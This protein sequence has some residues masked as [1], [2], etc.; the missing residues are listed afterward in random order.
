VPLPLLHI[1]SITGNFSQHI[2]TGIDLESVSDRRAFNRPVRIAYCLKSSPPVHSGKHT[3]PIFATLVRSS[4][5]LNAHFESRRE[6]GG[7]LRQLQASASFII[8]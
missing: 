6:G 5:V 7:G 2:Y 4:E 8:S 1:L 3:R